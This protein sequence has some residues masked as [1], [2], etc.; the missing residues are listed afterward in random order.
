[1]FYGD[2]AGLDDVDDYHDRDRTGE[3]F[4]VRKF[5]GD[6]AGLDDVDEDYYDHDDGDNSNDDKFG[7]RMFHGDAAGL[8]DVDD[9]DD[10]ISDSIRFHDVSKNYESL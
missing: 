9:Y 8:D 4:E 7:T 1:M 10:K 2:A 3:K 5:H 6:A